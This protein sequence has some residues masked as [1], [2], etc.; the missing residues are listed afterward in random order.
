MCLN[1]LIVIMCM[2]RIYTCIYMCVLVSLSSCNYYY[3]V[4]CA[5][6]IC[7][8]CFIGVF[9]RV[10]ACICV[11]IH[12]SCLLKFVCIH[13]WVGGV[14]SYKGCIFLQ[15]NQCVASVFDCVNLFSVWQVYF[16]LYVSV[17]LFMC[18]YVWNIILTLLVYVYK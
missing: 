10:C 2:Y 18:G 3:R 14:L 17:Y 12:L 4:V 16:I 13:F 1:I 8:L 11:Q 5:E 9:L 6:S 7:S 15:F